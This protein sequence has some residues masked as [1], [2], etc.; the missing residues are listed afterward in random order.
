VEVVA[1]VETYLEDIWLQPY[2]TLD[3]AL[4]PPLD[5]EG[6][7][8]K[9]G[10]RSLPARLRH[11][12]QAWA[13]S[14][15]SAEGRVAFSRV[16]WDSY[17][18]EVQTASGDVLMSDVHPLPPEGPLVLKVPLTEIEGR[19]H[20]GDAPVPHAHLTVS[21][22]AA[23]AVSFRTNEVQS[24]RLSVELDRA[25]LYRMPV[26]RTRRGNL[27]EERLSDG[28]ADAAREAALL[29][30]LWTSCERLPADGP[31]VLRLPPGPAATLRLTDGTG[32]APDGRSLWLVT[33]GGGMLNRSDLAT[34]HSMVG[35]IAEGEPLDTPGLAPDVYRVV[36]WH[37][38]DEGSLVA[39]ACA[40]AVPGSGPAATLQPGDTASL[41]AQTPR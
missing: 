30:M 21:S 3:I 35:A 41:S 25:H 4:V 34:W 5:P 7:S 31:L 12:T 16:T 22:G 39:R 27:D 24:Y 8:W 38:A 20:R 33:S 6:G 40:G 28:T 11:D 15:A 10:I 9:V 1:D 23:D 19:L 2:R 17:E 18:V 26:R 32:R 13:W 37:G 36:W 29:D 14:S